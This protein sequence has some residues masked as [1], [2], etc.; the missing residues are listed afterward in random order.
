[1][2]TQADRDVHTRAGRS[3]QRAQRVP[4][5]DDPDRQRDARAEAYTAAHEPYCE[6]GPKAK[7]SRG[8]VRTRRAVRHEGAEYSHPPPAVT[9][10]QHLEA[11]GVL[12]QI[13]TRT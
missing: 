10:L 6:R 13:G 2:R 3:A 5:V 8:R 9:N 4:D 7:C 1:G 11:R 12:A